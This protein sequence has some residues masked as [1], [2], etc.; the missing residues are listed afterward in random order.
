MIFRSTSRFAALVALTTGLIVAAPSTGEAREAREARQ[1]WSKASVSCTV[2]DG[3]IDEASGISRSTYHR[4]LFFMHNDSGDSARFFAVGQ[5]CRTKAMFRVRNTSA[6]DWEDMAAGRHHKLWFG[7]IG[8]NKT[9]RSHITLVRV[10]EPRKMHSRTV[11]GTSFQLKYADGPHNAEALMVQPRSGRI[12]IVTKAK[13]GAGIYRAPKHLSKDRINVLKRVASVPFLVTGADFQPNG[14]HFVI[15]TYSDAYLYSRIRGH[16]HRI[17]L[18][19]QRQGEAIM[20]TRGG[21]ALRVASE[22]VA[23]PVW[24]ID[25]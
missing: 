2:R 1:A 19:S 18:P 24:R 3:R 10:R 25:R 20:Y 21:H 12:Y 23:Q 22:G 7:D 13:S 16:G 15:R 5:K 6:A 11:H 9:H 4:G 8:D 17:D 14:R